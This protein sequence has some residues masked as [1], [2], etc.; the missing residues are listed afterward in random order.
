M[1][2][3][4]YAYQLVQWFITVS[5]TGTVYPVEEV[6]LMAQIGVTIDPESCIVHKAQYLNTELN[7]NTGIRS[8]IYLKAAC[9]EKGRG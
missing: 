9:V 7:N 3:H 6:D 4:I 8:H 5:V 2:L 1:K